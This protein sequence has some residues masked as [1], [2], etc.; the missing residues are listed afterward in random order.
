MPTTITSD[1]EHERRDD[2]DHDQ[3]GGSVRSSPQHHR[4]LSGTA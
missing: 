3:R 1:D 4:P 2:G